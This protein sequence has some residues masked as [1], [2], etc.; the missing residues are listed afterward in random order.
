MKQVC[1]R[2]PYESDDPNQPDLKKEAMN[3][4]NEMIE[5]LQRKVNVAGI[6][7]SSFELSD[8][9]YSS[10]IAKAMLVK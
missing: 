7:I 8:L 2:Y 5:T 6:N 1:S 10:E 3:I 4:S 9:K